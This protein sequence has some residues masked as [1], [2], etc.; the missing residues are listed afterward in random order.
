MYIQRLLYFPTFYAQN[1]L[2]TTCNPSLPLLKKKEN[3][4]DPLALK[5]LLKKVS[6]N[7]ESI[8]NRRCFMKSLH[9]DLA[10][11]A[12][13]RNIPVLYMYILSEGINSL[14]RGGSA[15]LPE[16]HKSNWLRIG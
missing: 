4:I 12:D 3:R 10:L 6:L 1:L 5:F 9:L 7:P 8:P 15:F 11:E 13:T 2:L 14:R 16:S